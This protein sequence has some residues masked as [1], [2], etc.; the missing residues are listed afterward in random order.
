MSLIWFANFTAWLHSRSCAGVARCGALN[1]PALEGT[2]PRRGIWSMR[3]QGNSLLAQSSCT[4]IQLSFEGD[5]SVQLINILSTSYCFLARVYRWQIL[6]VTRNSLSLMFNI[7]EK[8]LLN[9]LGKYKLRKV[10]I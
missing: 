6:K 2:P 1:H 9:Y 8:K 5:L 3:L 7:Y 4:D 10:R